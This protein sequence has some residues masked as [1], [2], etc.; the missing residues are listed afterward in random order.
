MLPILATGNPITMKHSLLS[1]LISLLASAAIAQVND[2]VA[3]RLGTYDKAF[4]KA[5][6]IASI[7][8]EIAF[9]GTSYHRQYSFD[10]QGNLAY[11]ATFNKKGQKA[12]ES[13]YKF[14]HY[15]DKIY[16]K[17]VDYRNNTSD[18]SVYDRIYNGNK[19]VRESSKQ[20]GYS[21]E[22]VYN[23]NGQLEKTITNNSFGVSTST[24]YSYDAKGHQ[25]ELL[26]TQNNTRKLTRNTYNNKGQLIEFQE[27]FYEPMDTAGKLFLHKRLTYAPNGKLAREEYVDGYRG[28]D[29]DN[30]EYTY[31]RKA[32]LVV[33]QKG[34]EK[35][36]YVYNDKGYLIRKETHLADSFDNSVETYSYSFSK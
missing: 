19:Q 10:K 29:K 2:D 8:V 11:A 35:R 36:V 18:S 14:N 32:N 25:T 15:G 3:Y 30:I 33:C 5:N 17:D 20:A 9:A 27:Q 34:E 13:Y 28:L 23:S 1:I 4:I 26:W 21:T 22:Y 6:K 16:E 7:K 31:D 12:N 24:V